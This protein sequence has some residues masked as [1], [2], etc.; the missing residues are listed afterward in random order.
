MSELSCGLYQHGQS[1]DKYRNR[2]K[3]LRPNSSCVKEIQ[4]QICICESGTFAC[5][6]WFPNNYQSIS[7]YSG[8]GDVPH[9]YVRVKDAADRFSEFCERQTQV[10]GEQC[11]G[12]FNG[13]TNG[14]WLNMTD[15]CVV[16][17]NR[18]CDN[19]AIL[20][21]FDNCSQ[22]DLPPP[23]PA[24]PP[25][26]HPSPPPVMSPLLTYVPPP[27]ILQVDEGANSQAP[28][29][30]PAIAA[31]LGLTGV[32]IGV[33]LFVFYRSRRSRRTQSTSTVQFDV[34]M[35]RIVHSSANGIPV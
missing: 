28:N 19:D 31:S 25:V 33:A 4:R 2:Y 14:S 21:T 34:P 23:T 35:A 11:R 7:C 15:W 24:I 30:I 16:N 32:V 10:K 27:R 9:E 8:C 6:D 26:P 3:L 29:I 18:V 22:P 1:R 12:H 5:T 20:Y 13:N 17:G